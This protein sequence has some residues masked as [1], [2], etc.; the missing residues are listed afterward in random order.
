[1]EVGGGGYDGMVAYSFKYCL[2]LF[3]S[4]LIKLKVPYNFTFS[5]ILYNMYNFH[6]SLAKLSH[7]SMPVTLALMDSKFYI[8]TFVSQ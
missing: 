2:L 1:L 7:Y 6:A 8:K 4:S 3:A 5:A